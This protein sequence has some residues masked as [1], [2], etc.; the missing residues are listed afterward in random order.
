MVLV[1]PFQLRTLCNGNM[2][3]TL[4]LLCFYSCDDQIHMK[5]LKCF[6][7]GSHKFNS[8]R[9]FA[10]AGSTP[11][12]AHSWEGRKALSRAACL[13]FLSLGEAELFTAGFPRPCSGEASLCTAWSLLSSLPAAS[14]FEP[15]AGN[16]AN[17]FR[18]VSTSSEQGKE[19]EDLG[20]CPAPAASAGSSTQAV[21]GGDRKKAWACMLTSKPCSPQSTEEK[22]LTSSAAEA[23][24]WRCWLGAVMQSLVGSRP[25]CRCGD[26]LATAPT[27]APLLRTEEMSSS[28]HYWSLSSFLLLLGRNLGALIEI[29]QDSVN[30]T[31]GQPMLLPVSYRF[32]GAILFPVSISWT[33]SNSSNT[34]I[35]CALQ[36]CSLDARGAPSN[37][38]AEFFP[39]KTYRDRAALFPLNGSLLLWDLRLSDGGVYAVT[40]RV[41]YQ[42]GNGISRQ[43]H[44]T[45]H[46]TFRESCHTRNITLTVHEQRFTSEHPAETVQQD[47][48]RNCAIAICSSASLLLLLLLFCCMRHRGAAQQQKRK[49]TEQQQVSGMEKAHMESTGGAVVTIYATIGN[50]FEQPPPRPTPEVVYTSI[51][52]LDPP[53]LNTRP[54]HLLV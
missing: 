1:G 40:F 30:G 54:Y 48:I 51:T 7:G 6:R 26:Q 36:N 44:S 25:R 35:A 38:S 50:S 28:W 13:V 21:V 8:K 41:T 34:V 9:V 29:H 27:T 22:P 32:D 31:V 11:G 52:S 3:V 53:G 15:P 33:F 19:A 20:S 16:S 4:D 24:P 49:I 14:R 46:S 39:Q 47:L 43:L 10:T 18:C 2:A 42:S 45:R 5:R 12:C 17:T 23:T 37:C